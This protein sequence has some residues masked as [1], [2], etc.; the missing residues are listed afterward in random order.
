NRAYLKPDGI[1]LR[2]RFRM[3]DEII[4]KLIADLQQTHGIR[5]AAFVKG[6]LFAE[7]SVPVT[8]LKR[9]RLDVSVKAALNRVRKR[10][11]L[12][13]LAFKHFVVQWCSQHSSGFEFRIYAAGSP[14][15]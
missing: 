6:Q 14:T 5:R 11:H 2:E 12:K 13:P 1:I 10:Q 4:E 8:E 3:A 9:G 7:G 15:P